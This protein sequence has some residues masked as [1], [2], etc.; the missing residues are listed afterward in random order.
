MKR[1]NRCI[2]V[3]LIFLL[4]QSLFT[5][6]SIAQAAPE[7]VGRITVAELKA[8]LDAGDDVAVV[9]VRSK[10]AFDNGH[11]PNAISMP[12]ADISKRH[13]ELKKHPLLVLY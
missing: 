11:L 5:T 2:F 6:P 3:L 4:V 1:T 7:D 10:G 8:K 12:T 9:D 13:Q